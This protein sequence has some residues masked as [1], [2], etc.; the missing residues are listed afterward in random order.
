M[1]WAKITLNINKYKRIKFN[2]NLN[3]NKIYFLNLYQVI[4]YDIL[5]QVVRNKTEHN[6]FKL[7]IIIKV[8]ELITKT[9]SIIFSKQI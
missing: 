2:L 1:P 4:A 7:L 9:V 6:T 5:L 8:R 3:F